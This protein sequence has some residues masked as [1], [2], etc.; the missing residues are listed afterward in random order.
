MI[1]ADTNLIV[2]L[3]VRGVHTRQAERVYE[4]DAA[5]I[6]RPLWRSEFRNA[7]AIHRRTGALSAGEIFEIVEKA[8]RM[9]H[10]KDVA[11][12]SRDVLT[13]TFGSRC[14]AYD[15]EFVALAREFGVPLVTNDR[16]V[17]SEFPETA[18]SIEAFAA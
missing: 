1:V 7:L 15:C 12:D 16:L 10:G 18:V 3:T 14:V 9:M 4:R 2:Y 6:A 13:L 17:L 5:W 11:V 8:E